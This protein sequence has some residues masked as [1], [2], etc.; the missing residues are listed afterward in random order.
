MPPVPAL[1][2]L[3]TPLPLPKG[4]SMGGEGAVCACAPPGERASFHPGSAL[5]ARCF[6]SSKLHNLHCAAIDVL[7][8]KVKSDT[9]PGSGCIDSAWLCAWVAYV[10]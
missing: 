8:D 7:L 5:F 2:L 6:F 9:E 1:F 4:K 10:V 3:L